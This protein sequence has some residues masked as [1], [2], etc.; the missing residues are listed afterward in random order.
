MDRINRKHYLLKI[1]MVIVVGFNVFI[2]VKSKTTEKYY[3]EGL[4]EKN[5]LIELNDSLFIRNLELLSQEI[6]IATNTIFKDAQRI[7]PVLIYVY[8][9]DECGRCIFQDIEILKDRF[10]DNN[11]KDII[12]LPVLENTRNINIA[13][14]ADLAGINYK[15]LD[16]K[17]V[18]SP[19]F[20]GFSVRFFAVLLPS[21][22]LKLTFFPNL[23]N[24]KRIGTYLDFVIGKY[25]SCKYPQNE[26]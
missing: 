14:K 6:N 5:K 13:L 24:P 17:L 16:A 19:K 1:A 22:E 21:G 15:R 4:K 2:I 23:A 20:N 18:E 3:N 11:S 8:S 25:F 10:G 9:G 7:Y 26:S 12:V